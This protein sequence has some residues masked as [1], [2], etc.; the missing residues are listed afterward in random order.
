MIVSGTF[1]LSRQGI[2]LREQAE[3]LTNE[4]F[5][6]PWSVLVQAEVDELYNLLT[7]LHAGLNVYRK[8]R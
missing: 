4:Y 1:R 8:S 6:A 5:Y 3:H 7:T 2:E